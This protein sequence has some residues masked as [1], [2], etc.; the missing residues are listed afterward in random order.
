MGEGFKVNLMLCLCL[1]TWPSIKMCW[2]LEVKLHKLSWVLDDWE[3][4]AVK[5]ALKLMYTFLLFMSMGWQCVFELRSPCGLSFIPQMIIW[6]WSLGGM[7]LTGE[8][9]RTQ[10]KAC[11]S[12]T[13][14]TTNHMWTELDLHS[15]RP[16]TDHL[17]YGC[18]KCILCLLLDGHC[19]AP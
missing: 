4:K 17:S 2:G 1:R 19:P 7:I 3:S 9:Q 12:A 8:D 16:A 14:S 13:L 11:P 5:L 10:R 15:V 6:V 18:D